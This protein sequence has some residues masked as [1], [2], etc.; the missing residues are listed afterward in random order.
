[1]KKIKILSTRKLSKE[2][3]NKFNDLKFD[4]YQHDFISIEPLK[5]ILPEHKGSW[6]FTS[7]NAVEAIF[8]N[9]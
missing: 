4:F 6:I 7:K 1:M 2:L 9:K 3:K 8:F 5:I